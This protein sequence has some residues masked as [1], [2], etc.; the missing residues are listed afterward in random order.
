MNRKSNWPGPTHGAMSDIIHGKYWRWQAVHG[1]LSSER[2]RPE[3]RKRVT[4]KIIHKSSIERQWLCCY[5][6]DNDGR[7]T[8]VLPGRS[9]PG[10]PQR[11]AGCVRLSLTLFAAECRFGVIEKLSNG[12]IVRISSPRGGMWGALVGCGGTLSLYKVGQ[13]R[14]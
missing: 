11:R 9:R 8:F 14:S 3:K 5:S 13:W 1:Q 7:K 10:F 6:D 12:H 4:L 2:S